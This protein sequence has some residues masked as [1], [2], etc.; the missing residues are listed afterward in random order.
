MG[1][2]QW[3]KLASRT[4]WYPDSLDYDGA[5]CYELGIKRKWKHDLIPTYV[6]KTGNLKTRMSQYARNGSHLRKLLVKYWKYDYVLWFRY[7]PLENEAKA[8]TM[9]EKSLS[10]FGL[11]RYPWNSNLGG[12]Q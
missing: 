3:K 8:K 12:G 10:D 4:D 9:E 2:T 1:W 6:G 7:Y 5:A 11:E